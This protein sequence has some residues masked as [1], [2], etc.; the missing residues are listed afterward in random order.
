MKVKF[1]GEVE[2]SPDSLAHMYCTFES[3]CLTYP[4]K[5]GEVGTINFQGYIADRFKRY[6]EEGG[7]TCGFVYGDKR[8]QEAKETLTQW[9][10]L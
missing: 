3:L 8:L 10:L 1:S 7:I 6:G 2:L 4:E 9:G 5:F